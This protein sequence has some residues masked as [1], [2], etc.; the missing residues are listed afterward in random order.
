LPYRIERNM[1]WKLRRERQHWTCSITILLAAVGGMLYLS[2]AGQ[3]Q[4]QEARVHIEPRVP[5]GDPAGGQ[6]RIRIDSNLVLIPVMVT[7]EQDRLIT[8]L[9]REHFRLWE[10]KIEQVISNFGVEDAPV[11]VGLVFDSSGS[12]GVKLTRSRAAVAEF[13]RTANPEDEFS[14]VEFSDGARLTQGFTDRMDKIQNQ[15]MFIQARGQ[16]ALLDAV[17][18]SLEEM[19]HAKH[20]RKVLLIISDGGDNASRYTVR[21]VKSRLREADV[22]VYS[23]GIM[24][25][26]SFRNRTPEEMQGAG[27]LDDLAR[28]TGGRLFEA[29]DINDLPTIAFKIGTALRNQYVLGYVPTAEKRDGKYH[30][31]QVKIARLKGMPPLHASFRAGYLAPGN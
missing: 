7:D 30:R 12:M 3:V 26:F 18:L 20:S 22:Q 16:T 14:L 8:G 21:D 10:D 17:I 27:L 6:P 28:Q 23:I 25:P 31:V 15:M 24:E 4:A 5:S 29:D 13:L 11:S 2:N 1:E 9:A 19:R